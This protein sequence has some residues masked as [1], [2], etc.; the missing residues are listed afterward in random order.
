MSRYIHNQSKKKRILPRFTALLLALLFLIAAPASVY[1]AS[2]SDGRDRVIDNAN[3]FTAKE[4]KSLE[5]QV[6]DA[7]DTSGM[8]L[9]VLTINDADGKTAQAY[10]DDYYDQNDFGT[11]SD[12][13][14]ALY[15]I[16]MD[17][18]EIAIST[19]GRMTR[20]LTDERIDSILD[21][22]YEKVAKGQYA[23]SA[24][25]AIS[26][27]ASFVEAGIP[28]GQYKYDSQTGKADY[29]KKRS[30]TWYNVLFALGAAGVIAILPCIATV[31][32]YKM[33][34]AH[35]QALNYRMS[36]R[37]GSAFAFHNSNDLFVNRI[38]TQR[39]IQRDSN[40]GYGGGRGG[41][42]SGRSTTH[43]SSSG[44]SHGGGSRKF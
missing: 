20:Y 31:N 36:Y 24:K 25:T 37:S 2:G 8:D 42:F 1:A 23:A 27:I 40:S 16:D 18:R 9:V 43:R 21:A 35:R 22:A 4:K 26:K 33:K 6:K 11:G 44:R 39:R 34:S 15:L 12:H 10:A 7:R 38:V 32:Q 30:I 19:L 5:E 41:G 29:Y 14:G 17:N 3:L 13:S 28:D